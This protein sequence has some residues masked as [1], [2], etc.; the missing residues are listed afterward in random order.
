MSKNIRHT[1][2]IEG[3]DIGAAIALALGMRLGVSDIR[4]HMRR[5][6]GMQLSGT[7]DAGAR[8]RWVGAMRATGLVVKKAPWERKEAKA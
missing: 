1:V 5:D 2:V 4:W 7:G 8:S 6:G 3:G